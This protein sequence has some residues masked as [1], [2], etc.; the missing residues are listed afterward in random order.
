MAWVPNG[1]RLPNTGPTR[2]P[3]PRLSMHFFP[4]R[5]QSCVIQRA[6]RIPTVTIPILGPTNT[7]ISASPDSGKFRPN[8][9]TTT[10]PMLPFIP[11]GGLGFKIAGRPRWLYGVQTIHPSRHRVPQY[12]S[13]IHPT[14]SFNRRACTGEPSAHGVH[15]RLMRFDHVCGRCAWRRYFCVHG[16]LRWCCTKK[17]FVRGLVPAEKNATPCGTVFMS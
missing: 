6:Q 14:R 16:V 3:T 9:F 11:S 2:R 5:R 12:S 10:A 13:V 4:W 1:P 15:E 17:A 8:C 7:P